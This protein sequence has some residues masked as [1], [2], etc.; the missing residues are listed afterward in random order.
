MLVNKQIKLYAKEYILYLAWFQ[1]FVATVGSLYFSLVRHLPPCDLCWYQRIFMYPLTIILA[2]GILKKDKN[3]YLYSLP[4]AIIGLFI[5]IYHVILQEGFIPKT[6]QP[7]S[8]GSISCGDKYLEILG[9][10]TIPLMSAAA[11]TLILICL[12]IHKQL[13]KKKK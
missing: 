1:A 7:C 6:L 5:A 11:F 12:I 8:L 9:F 13:N 3:I 10:I 4:F 2:V